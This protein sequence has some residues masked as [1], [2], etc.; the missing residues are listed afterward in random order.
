[1]TRSKRTFFHFSIQITPREYREKKENL[2]IW[3]KSDR[4]SFSNESGLFERATPS[5]WYFWQNEPCR[6]INSSG[7]SFRIFEVFICRR[8]RPSFFLFIYSLI[9]IAS[10]SQRDSHC[11]NVFRLLPLMKG[12][13]SSRLIR[14]SM[15]RRGKKSQNSCKNMSDNHLNFLMNSMS[16]FL[17]FA[18]LLKSISMF[19]EV[20]Y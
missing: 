2:C 5:P 1:M 18:V 20:R 14:I 15:K 17:S 3:Q 6:L 16:L 13:E 10:R 4:R 7:K 8:G 11:L 12:I 19:D 9:M